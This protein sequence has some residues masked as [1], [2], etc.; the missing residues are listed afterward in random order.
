MKTTARYS[1]R[2]PMGRSLVGFGV[3]L[4]AL[5]MSAAHAQ[6]RYSAYVMDADTNEVLHADA[7]ED[8]RFPASLTKMMT[9]Y[10]LF[11]AMERKHIGLQ[12]KMT[13]SKFAS[14]QAPTKLGLK[15]GDQ[16]SVDI[17]IKALVTKSANDVAVVIAERLGGSEP[18]FAAQMTARARELGMTSTRFVNAS[19]LPNAQQRTSAKDMATLGRAL[20]RDFPQYYGYFKTPGITWRAHYAKNHNGLLGRVEGLDGIK[21]GYTRMSGYN[22]TSSVERNGHRIVAVVMGGQ[23]PSARDAQMAH[24]IEGAFEEI[25]KRSGQ[26]LSSA[27]FVSM[28]VNRATIQFDAA[29][30]SEEGEDGAPIAPAGAQLPA[31]AAPKTPAPTAPVTVRQSMIDQ[32]SY[33]APAPRYAQAFAMEAASGGGAP[34][35]GAQFIGQDP[36]Y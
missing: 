2:M 14:R 32:P 17:A 24:L 34:A 25:A 22:L 6:E 26:P 9:L 35:A 23:S 12:D 21:T 20:V 4:A 1:T 3:A 30:D 11:E 10:M 28:P 18:R 15:K 7:A 36:L 33:V 27:T 16:I 13:A 8:S 31:P 19:G 29:K 5:S